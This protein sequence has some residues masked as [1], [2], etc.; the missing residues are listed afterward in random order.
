MN[1]INNKT[2]NNINV[3]ISKKIRNLLMIFLL[4]SG[5]FYGIPFHSNTTIC[6]EKIMIA[7]PEEEYQNTEEECSEDFFN[8][9]AYDHEFEEWYEKLLEK[10]E[11][12]KE[13]KNESASISREQ[14]LEISG[15]VVGTVILANGMVMV[16]SQLPWVLI[17]SFGMCNTGV[18]VVGLELMV[19]GAG[20]AIVLGCLLAEDSVEE[21]VSEVP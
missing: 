21:N 5:M 2:L 11:L 14:A 19:I 16:Y 13:K 6:S 15:I 18:L 20:V 3:S 8:E 1:T 9:V 4:C 12:R 7:M 17:W 10:Q